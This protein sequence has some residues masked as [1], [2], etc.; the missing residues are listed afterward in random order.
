[1]AGSPSP[2]LPKPADLDRDTPDRCPGCGQPYTYCTP[3]DMDPNQRDDAGRITSAAG[4]AGSIRA[5]HRIGSLKPQWGG[6]EFVHT[7]QD[8]DQ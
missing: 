1:M 6:W 8:G 3:Q 7:D 2:E 5:T 4:A